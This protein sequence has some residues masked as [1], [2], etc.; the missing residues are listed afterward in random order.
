MFSL[1]DILTYAR[2]GAQLL[3]NSTASFPLQ[4]P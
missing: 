2:N 3:V 4:R 1:L